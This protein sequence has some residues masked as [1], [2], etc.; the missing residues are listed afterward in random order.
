MLG[1]RDGGVRT[2]VAVARRW[3]WFPTVPLR[4][5]G[6]AARRAWRPAY[7]RRIAA[8]DV[9]AALIAAA[10]GYQVR[11][12]PEVSPA[13]HRMSLAVVVVLPV[14]WLLGMLV[15]RAYEERF[16]WLGPEEFRRVFFAAALMLATVG[17]LSWAFKLEVARGFIIVALPLATALTLLQRCG[18]RVWLHRQRAH[19]HYQ[20]TAVIVGHRAGVAALHE[21][22]DREAY[23]GYRIIGCCIPRHPHGK[24]SVLFDELP[25]LGDLDDVVDVVQRY[26]VDTVAVLPSPELDGAALR[27][28]GW[29]LE[30]T[31]AEL[32]LAPAITEI[33]GTRV[34]IRPVCGLPLLHMERPELRGVRR[35]TKETV[36]RCGAAAA[37]GLMLLVLAAAALAVR[38]TSR[39]PVFFRQARVGRD[40]ET[41]SMLK[42][43]S[44]VDGAD[45]M[46][47]SLDSEGNGVLFKMRDD[48]RITRVGGFLR[49]YSIDELPQL[50]NVLRGDMSLVGPRPP[51]PSEVE[52]YGFDMHRRFLVKPGIT[53][54]WQVSGRSDLS[55][56]DS[57]RIDV[58]YVENWSLMF[59]FMIMW[60]TL[61]A[62]FRGRGAY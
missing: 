36:D 55:W 62:V 32:L 51:L 1:Q 56:D 23:H 5:E 16:L 3:R 34:R 46:V 43:R 60:K 22:I 52:R 42:F 48:P 29:E 35:L 39:G 8:G 61:G 24:D 31:E 27:R 15:A 54:L 20:Q 26:E 6:T 59:D 30:Q 13:D 37:L 7:V 47:E 2:D 4:G 19:G 11:F 53:G 33:V 17:T 49:R 45:R 50:I 41:F 9:I 58:R 28:L 25:V 18:N 57:V 40:G 12:G 10:A 44:M 38:V 21:Q 14:V